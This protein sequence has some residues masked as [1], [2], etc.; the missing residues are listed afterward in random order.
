[1]SL[2]KELRGIARTLRLKEERLDTWE[3]DLRRRE[4]WLMWSK[5]DT[6]KREYHHHD[7]RAHYKQKPRRPRVDDYSKLAVP[8]SH[9]DSSREKA[10]A[11]GPA[12]EPKNNI[13]ETSS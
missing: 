10:P 13:T 6:H 2:E 11:E 8:R 5:R 3:R 12:D 4:D 9:T 7:G 1:M